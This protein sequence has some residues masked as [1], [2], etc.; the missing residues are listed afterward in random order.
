MNARAKFPLTYLVLVLAPLLGIYFVLRSG[1]GLQALGTAI[2]PRPK[3]PSESG[4]ALQLPV[5]LLQAIVIIG[6][7]RLVGLVVGR[8]RQPQVVGEMLAGIL[9][10]PTILGALAP[11][12]FSYVFPTGSLR[13]LN[14][15]SQIG[16][17]LFMFLVGLEFD[18]K[19]MEGRGHAAVLT[20]HASILAPMLLGTALAIWVYPAFGPPGVGFMPFALFLGAAMSVTAFPV[21]ARIL[22]ER[23]MQRSRLGAIAIACAAVDDVTAWC[24][25]AVVVVIA[26]AG[27]SGTPLWVT[28]AGAGAF[29]AV[30][31][32]V[33][34][35][36]LAGAW[37]R[38][39]DAQAATYQ[40]VLAG[41]L[42]VVLG[43]AWVTERLGV[44]ALFGAFV[45]GVAMPK[46]PRLM[47]QL[48]KRFE[49]LMVALLLP[50]FFAY[51]GLRMRVG[52]LSGGGLWMLFGAV[53]LTAVLG[54][55]GGSA[56]AARLTGLS[57]GES[58][59]V[60]ALMNTRGLM[61]LIILNVGLDLGVISPPVFTVMVLM[62][63]TTTFM[64][65]PLV[66]WWSPGTRV[67][68]QKSLR[69]TLHEIPQV[70]LPE[71]GT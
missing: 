46:D 53:L 47:R 10:G 25:L 30:M 55:L 19:A 13:F 44:H 36:L 61:E 6:A 60:G 22:T 37:R 57:W 32:F 62:A 58:L 42:L 24:I 70:V 45:A 48:A 15:L 40:E 17:V 18:P 4:P 39:F 66:E 33:M 49:D 38:I 11:G 71:E 5:L 59:T 1:S 26:R 21:L 9:L 67:I 65:T 23:G 16:L 41:S 43:S 34:R 12:L 2:A 20:S 56:V 14:T 54:K 29:V 64:T 69:T 35:P 27:S 50:L 3:G 7:S 63:L 51:T 31:L 8:F 68:A 28:I 52:L